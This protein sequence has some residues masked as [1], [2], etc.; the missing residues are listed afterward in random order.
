[1]TTGR[2]YEF[3]LHSPVGSLER[4][5][6]LAEEPPVRTDAHLEAWVRTSVGGR[7]SPDDARVE[8][9]RRR[10][11]EMPMPERLPAWNSL[12]IADN[13]EIWARRFAIPGAETI[14]HDVFRADGNLLAQVMVPANLRVQHV[15]EGS[16]TVVSSDGLGVERVEVC[17]LR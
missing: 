15:G 11:E 1:M 7:E 8:A 13:G 14:L 16:L 12:L 5:V 2:S 3:S 17:E 6:R 9:A 4:I 10:Y